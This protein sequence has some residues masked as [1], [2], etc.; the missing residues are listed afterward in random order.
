MTSR[1]TELGELQLAV[2]QILWSRQTATVHDVLADFPEERKPAYTT[3]LTVLRNLE[4]RGLVAHEAAAGSR[5][6]L[7]RPMVSAEEMRRVALEDLLARLFAGSPALLVEELCAAQDVSL[8][9]LERI[10]QCVNRCIRQ[11]S[12]SDAS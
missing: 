12:D 1:S 3:A 4:K 5:M 11:I 7:Y 6:F 2:L 10:R 8:P 9:E